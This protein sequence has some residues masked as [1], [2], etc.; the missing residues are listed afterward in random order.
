MTFQMSW[1]LSDNFFIAISALQASISFIFRSLISRVSYLKEPL[2]VECYVENQRIYQLC[3]QLT[4]PN[5]SSW[6]D[7]SPNKS[8]K[9]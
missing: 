1:K 2:V 6:P 8:I 7:L 5:D 3:Y 4:V 9:A